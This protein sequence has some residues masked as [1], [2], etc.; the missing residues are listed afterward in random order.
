MRLN[1]AIVLSVVANCGGGRAILSDPTTGSGD[2]KIDGGA[3]SVL[4]APPL[5]LHEDAG[6]FPQENVQVVYLI[7]TDSNRP[8]CQAWDV[9]TSE[10]IGFGTYDAS[11]DT[12]RYFDLV[13]RP[14]SSNK[15]IQLKLIRRGSMLI[16]RDPKVRWGPRDGTPA[17]LASCEEEYRAEASNSESLRFSGGLRFYLDE[18]AC[19]QAADVGELTNLGK[20]QT[21]LDRFP[22]GVELPPIDPRPILCAAPF[23]DEV[24]FFGALPRVVNARNFNLAPASP[25]AHLDLY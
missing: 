15:T 2:R 22:R 7:V 16:V 4:A 5:D 13:Q 9:E 3:S 11:D 14:S 8:R 19:S 18:K 6:S 25:T 1:L 10:R 23:A 21:V 20:C 12:P 17:L 24:P